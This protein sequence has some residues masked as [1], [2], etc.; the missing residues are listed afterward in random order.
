MKTVLALFVLVQDSSKLKYEHMCICTNKVSY[1]PCWARDNMDFAEQNCLKWTFLWFI[2][3][4]LWVL[5]K[6]DLVFC[7]CLLFLFVMLVP[8]LWVKPFSY[9]LFLC[10]PVSSISKVKRVDLLEACLTPPYSLCG[11]PE[12]GNCCSVIVVCCSLPYLYFVVLCL[13]FIV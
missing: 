4:K 12:S 5:L 1:Y 2:I 10:S 8:I 7:F 11:C 6:H 3:K 13:Y 9:D